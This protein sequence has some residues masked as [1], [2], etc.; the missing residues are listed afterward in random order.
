MLVEHENAGAPLQVGCHQHL[1]V[2]QT[3]LAIELLAPTTDTKRPQKFAN[4]SVSI[5][6][7]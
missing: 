5:T 1:C 4:I 6:L 2:V 3:T 7:K